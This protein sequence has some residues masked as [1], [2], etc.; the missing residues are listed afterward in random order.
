MFRRFFKYYFLFVAALVV[1]GCE[2]NRPDNQK[3]VA[4]VGEKKLFLSEVAAVIPNNL[5]PEDSAAMAGDYMRKWVRQELVLQKAEENL[6]S[7]LK[8]VSRE[9][10]E[11]RNSLIVFRYKNELMAQRMDTTVSNSKI[12]D[13]YSKNAENFKLAKAIV[14]AIFM[15]VPA[16]FA[17]PETLKDLAS[18]TSAPGIDEIR[19]YCLQYAKSFAIYA[20]KWIEL[21][22]VMQ[23]I[24]IT[25]ENPE[26]FLP[27]NQFIE[28]ADSSYYYLV[29]IQDY[30]LKNEQGPVDYVQDNIKSLILNRRKITF[31]KEL[32]DNIFQE[33]V[34]RNNFKIYNSETDE[35]K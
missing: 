9:L 23:N 24:P 17:N 21:D 30:M 3:V 15:K 4:K 34:N 7:E 26:Q 12:M 1:F 20:D 35:T 27:R 29:A 14:K 31:L 32:E 19:D 33:G 5:A 2:H 28:Y 13:Y 25:I 22:A 16:D 8:D 18:D 6:S 10:Q 11:Y